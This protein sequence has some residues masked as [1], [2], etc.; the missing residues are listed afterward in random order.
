MVFIEFLSYVGLK[1]YLVKMLAINIKYL[2]NYF[3]FS[4]VW[5]SGTTGLGLGEESPGS[6]WTKY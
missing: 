2:I 1:N 6:R 5:S 3:F 4:F